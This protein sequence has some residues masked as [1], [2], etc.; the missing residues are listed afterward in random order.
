[1]KHTI[2]LRSAPGC[3]GGW[4]VLDKIKKNNKEYMVTKDHEVVEMHLRKA[5]DEVW[6]RRVTPDDPYTLTYDDDKNF[7]DNN[8]E[9][10]KLMCELLPYHHQMITEG[11]KNPNSGAVLLFEF[12]DIAMND[13]RNYNV[14][15]MQ[16]AAVNKVWDMSYREK[17]DLMYFFGENP[18][19]LG[20]RALTQRLID[21][22][23]AIV[24][25]RTDFGRSGK[26]HL[27]YFVEDYKGA[28][29]MSVLKAAIVKATMIKDAPIK[30]EGRIFML[31]DKVLGG[32]VEEVVNWL[33]NNPKMKDYLL[34]TVNQNDL[35][36][37]DDFEDAV[38]FANKTGDFKVVEKTDDEDIVRKKAK[39]FLIQHWHNLNMP[40]LKKKIAEAEPIFAKAKLY[41]MEDQIGRKKGATL[42][43][44]AEIV[45]A[46]EEALA[47]SQ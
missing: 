43:W 12:D 47:V 17:V 5:S 26:T 19:G 40:D 3:Q 34:N 37:P 11:F 28:D 30:K 38:E 46:K 44:V 39:S 1:M 32:T 7:K 45:K 23:G 41:E 13:V 22:G 6:R 36:D 29:P 2:I 16:R 33:V 42:E 20:Y 31:G 35:L 10:R 18:D 8:N 21:G 4:L 9:K 27:E 24:M 15:A 25:R 14:L